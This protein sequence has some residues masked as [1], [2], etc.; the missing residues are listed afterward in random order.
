MVND[1]RLHSS[2]DCFHCRASR[3][4]LP[5]IKG[6]SDPWRAGYFG[7]A[8]RKYGILGC[9]HYGIRLDLGNTQLNDNGII[10]DVCYRGAGAMWVGYWGP[11]MEQPIRNPVGANWD[12]L[13]CPNMVLRPF[14]QDGHSRQ[15]DFGICGFIVLRQ[16]RWGSIRNVAGPSG[17]DNG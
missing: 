15:V 8:K 5:P 4:K 1:E 16:S 14:N 3:F 11:P 2:T 12:C 17:A 7:C 9:W 6:Q 13:F 10:L